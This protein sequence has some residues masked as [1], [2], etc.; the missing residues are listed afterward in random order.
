MNKKHYGIYILFIVQF[1]EHLAAVSM[2]TVITPYAKNVLLI[3]VSLLG[4]LAGILS[5]SSMVSRFSAST[6]MRRLSYIRLI[7]VSMIFET[8]IYVCYLFATR[9]EVL[10]AV[11]LCNGFFAGITNTAIIALAGSML[12]SEKMGIG[13][14]VFGFS[15]MIALGIGPTVSMALYNKVGPRIFFITEIVIEATAVGM[16]F[17][18][19]NQ[20]EKKNAAESAK[21]EDKRNF[22]ARIILPS[23]ILPATLNLFLGLAYSS[24]STFIIVYGE[25]KNWK[26]V[27]LFYTVYALGSLIVRPVMGKIYDRKGLTLPVYISTI[28]FSASMVILAKANSFGVFLIAAV[29]MTIGFGGG[30]S[31]Y[32]AAALKCK[33]NRDKGAASA[34]FFLSNDIGLLVGSSVAGLCAERYGYSN[35]FLIFITPIICGFLVYILSLA[36]AQK[37]RI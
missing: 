16:S 13:I 4:V 9:Y 3:P 26:N 29:F 23:A 10:M 33:D 30:W 17:L 6:L 36:V 8:V 35:T 24:V 27:G 31:V 1:L 12:K 18:I 25:E 19:M 32:Q 11:R 37:R 15:Q 7:R 22:L 21:Q 5:V 2:R 14:G 34:T 20:D 28:L